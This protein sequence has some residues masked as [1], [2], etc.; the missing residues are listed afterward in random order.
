MEFQEV[1]PLLV[2]GP[3][4][5][6]F[7]FR[8]DRDLNELYETEYELPDGTK[9][10]PYTSTLTT[11]EGL[12]QSLASIASMG[13]FVYKGLQKRKA[14]LRPKVFLVGTH[15]DQLD[16]KTAN[17]HIARIDQQLQNA[18]KSTSHYKALVEFASPSQ[19]IFTVNN[20]SESESDFQGIRSA[21]ERVVV[22]DEFQMTSPA[23]WLIFSLALRKIKP[24]VVSYDICLEIARQCGLT[25]HEFDEALHFIHSKMGLIRY[26]PY[27]DVKDLVI[28]HPQFLFDKVTELIVNTFQVSI[29]WM[30]LNKRECFL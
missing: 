16:S 9:S 5:F 8:L 6:F 27:E 23:H 30:T 28:I 29:R 26:F 19:L 25:E 21:V 22:R 18:I 14:P 15:K 11:M 3:S 12:L 13:T 17:V 7:T 2:S 24:Y 1:L 20:F 10:E 4:V